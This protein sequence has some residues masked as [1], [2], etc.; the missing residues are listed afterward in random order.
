MELEYNGTYPNLCSGQ[1]IVTIDGKRWE[2]P[3]SCLVSGGRVW[4]D[5]GWSEHVD[6]GD[7]SIGEWPEHFP[8]CMK[9]QVV[10]LVN[11]EISHGCCG[12]C[13]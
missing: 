3:P 2:F 10:E 1:L 13:V 6:T 7:W 4:F 11:E 5:D 8:E 12:G 9:Y